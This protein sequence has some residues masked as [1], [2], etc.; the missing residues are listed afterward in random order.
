M[1]DITTRADESDVFATA[2]RNNAWTDRLRRYLATLHAYTALWANA[3]IKRATLL[4][5]AAD[6]WN[7]FDPITP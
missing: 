7:V 3:G 2:K 6:L 1:K 4:C 5:G